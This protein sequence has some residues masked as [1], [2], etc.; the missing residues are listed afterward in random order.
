MSDWLHGGALVQWK[1]SLWPRKGDGIMLVITGV[2]I[3]A[4][5]YRVVDVI[6]QT[7]AEK[8]PCINTGDLVKVQ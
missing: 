7:T 4:G 1:P 2:Y 6:D 5:G 3:S 8:I